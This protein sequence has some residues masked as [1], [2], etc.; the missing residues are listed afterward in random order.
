MAMTIDEILEMQAKIL[1][2]R[3]DTS[4]NPNMK[5]SGIASKNTGLNP[6]YFSG[7][8]TKIVNALNTVY[9]KAEDASDTAQKTKEKL[10]EIVLDTE[11]N[12]DEWTKLKGLMDHNTIVEGLVDLYENKLPNSSGGS[13]SDYATEEDIDSIINKLK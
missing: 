8:N 6:N 12:S 7:N 4:T 11:M 3:T 13:T 1:A 10:N 9:K 2:A 5:Y